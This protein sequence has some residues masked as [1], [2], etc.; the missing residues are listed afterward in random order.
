MAGQECPARVIALAVALVVFASTPYSQTGGKKKTDAGEVEV[1]FANG[2]VVRMAL[3]AEK[4]E[5]NTAY[6]KLLVP[7]REIRR[8]EFGLHLPEG[9]DQ[10]IETAIKQLGSAEY[11]ERVTAVRELVALEAYAYPALLQATK[12]GEPEV[13]KRA[14]EAI[15]QIKAKVPAKDLRLGEDDKVVTQRFTIVGRIVPTSIKA[16]SEYFGEVELSLAKLRHVRILGD[17]RD[18]EVVVDA[19]KYAQPNQWLDTGIELR[20]PTTLSIV[21]SGEVDLRPSLPGNNV[22]GPKGDTF[23]I[24]D[25]FEG[26]P[27]REGKLYLQIMASPY[28]NALSGSYQ[29]KVMTR[30]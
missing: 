16:R 24:G 21:A 10:K 30:E 22:C 8:I 5:I 13:A 17:S 1:I 11:K 15:A 18:A 6:G 7:V 27:D 23:A 2:S 26:V 12:S 20:G 29:V 4:I 14:Q 3:L 25:R 9:A 19:A 28:E